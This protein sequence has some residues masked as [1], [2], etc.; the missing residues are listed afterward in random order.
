MPGQVTVGHEALAAVVTEE[1]VLAAV[2]PLVPQ[3]VALHREL[4][5]ADLA[6][7]R[8]DVVMDLT[9]T[10]VEMYHMTYYLAHTIESNA[11]FGQL[12]QSIRL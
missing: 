6:H 11:N 3:Q 10:N 1:V 4:H 12:T 9:D 5:G 2:S 7:K 8:L